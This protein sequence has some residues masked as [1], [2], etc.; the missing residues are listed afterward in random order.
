MQKD[1]W[2]FG[3][4]YLAVVKLKC[5]IL[6]PLLTNAKPKVLINYL[7]LTLLGSY[8]WEF[9]MVGD[10]LSTSLSRYPS[11]GSQALLLYH[12]MT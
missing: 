2:K 10:S 4:G 11:E 3:R 6:S 7:S 9:T 8:P 12:I 5:I 1:G